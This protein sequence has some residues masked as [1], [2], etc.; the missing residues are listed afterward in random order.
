MKHRP[1]YSLLAILLAAALFAG[2]M[3]VVVSASPRDGRTAFTLDICHPLQAFDTGSARCDLPPLLNW[4]ITHEPQESGAVT[5]FAM[6]VVTRANEPP[7][8]P[9]PKALT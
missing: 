2:S 8:P 3:P 9:P 5:E 7:D 6:T 1:Q 4:S